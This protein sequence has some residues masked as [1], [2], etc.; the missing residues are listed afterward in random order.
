MSADKASR[1]FPSVAEY[2]AYMQKEYHY[3][4]TTP[5]YKRR[6]EALRAEEDQRKRYREEAVKNVKDAIGKINELPADI[7]SPKCKELYTFIKRHPK[8]KYKKHLSDERECGCRYLF[9]FFDTPDGGTQEFKAID[10]CDSKKHEGEKLQLKTTLTTEEFASL[11]PLCQ[12]RWIATPKDS[13]IAVYSKVS[14]CGCS[15]LRI[16][17]NYVDATGATRAGRCSASDPCVGHALGL[18]E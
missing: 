2:D 9:I 12:E 16:I 7:T 15:V 18:I 5:E 6:I 17:K 1:G 4:T 11:G 3:F 14:N 13:V 10:K 8:F